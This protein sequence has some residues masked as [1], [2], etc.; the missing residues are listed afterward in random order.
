LGLLDTTTLSTQATQWIADGMDS[1]NVRAL[2]GAAISG[3]NPTAEVLASLLEHIAAET[4][5]TFSS[6]QQAREVHS[7]AM[8]GS[9]EPTLEYSMRIL[10]ASNS[11]T[12]DLW[13]KF[14]TFLKRL[15]GRGPN[16]T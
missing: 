2:A 15:F 6:M 3:A 14:V 10:D 7:L 5:V 11:F 4:G 8:I 12:D 16:G 9:M 13:R 1:S